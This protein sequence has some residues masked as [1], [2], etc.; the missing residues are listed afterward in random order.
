MA[1]ELD[2]LSLSPEQVAQQLRRP[3][4]E[5]GVQMGHQMNKGNKH[6]CLNAYLALHPRPGSK[7]LEIGMGNGY[8]VKDL[9]YL[10]DD[11]RYAGI[12]YSQTMVDAAL[13]IN[14][15]LIDKGK[16]SF[17]HASIADLPFD[18]ATFDYITTTNTL[19]FWPDPVKDLA[20]L[21]RV[22]K[23]T[24]KL[25]I[26]YRSRAFLDQV[27][28]AKYGFSKFDKEDVED[29]LNGARFR[30]VRTTVV[31]EP[32]PVKLDGKQIALEGLFTEGIK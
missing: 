9:M 29:L 28:L 17:V 7:V 16:A 24:G 1:N 31:K 27:E 10:A 14:K 21:R 8:F 11:L 3:E 2:P 12:D 6:I 18:D 13:E 30:Q 25:V 4:G 22:M 23:P 32:D 26:G 19:Y 20:E 15:D 5:I